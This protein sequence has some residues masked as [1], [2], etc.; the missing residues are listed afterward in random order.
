MYS[1]SRLQCG[2]FN[3][4]AINSEPCVRFRFRPESGSRVDDFILRV[5]SHYR[6]GGGVSEH[7]NFSVRLQCEDGEQS[8]QAEGTD[9]GTA[10]VFVA[11]GADSVAVATIPGFGG[12]D[13][14]GVDTV[15]EVIQR[16]SCLR[17]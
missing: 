13:T 1:C 2:V 5:E 9:F 17:R 12:E 14:W 10:W 15:Y 4:A 7:L 6:S 8:S 11:E 16:P 3:V